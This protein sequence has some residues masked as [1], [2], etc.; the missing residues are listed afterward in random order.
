MSQD[1]LHQDEL[2]EQREDWYHRGD[3]SLTGSIRIPK[4]H[5]I[6]KKELTLED[7]SLIIKAL[8]ISISDN[9]PLF[10]KAK[11]QGLFDVSV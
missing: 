2:I 7:I 8:D 11:Q 1:A 6:T 3:N 4:T 10:E 9:H 5:K